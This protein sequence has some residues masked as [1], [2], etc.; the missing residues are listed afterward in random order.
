[1]LYDPAAWAVLQAGSALQLAKA[2]GIY[3]YNIRHWR[4]QRAVP[5]HR[6]Q[7]RILAVAK[8][9]GWDITPQ[10]MVV[11]REIIDTHRG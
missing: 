9:R 4:R 10:D 6:M 11:G 5:T 2:L 7:I 1:M 3:P 8:E